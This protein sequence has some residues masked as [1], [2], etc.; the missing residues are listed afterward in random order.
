MSSSRPRRPLTLR[1]KLLAQLIGLLALISV[2]IG[3]ITEVALSSYLTQQLDSQLSG[4]YGRAAEELGGQPSWPP[5]GRGPFNQPDPEDLLVRGQGPGTLGVLITDDDI[6]ARVISSRG[7]AQTVQLPTTVRSLPLT[8]QPSTL[9]LGGDLG[10]YRLAAGRT[11]GGDVM[12]IGLPLEDMHETLMR[13]AWIMGA[14]AVTGLLATAVIGAFTVRRTLRPLNRVAD[15]ASRVA[16]M[17]LD[18]GEVALS[19]RVPDADPRT[20]VGKVGDAVNR[21]IGHVANALAVRQ[22]SETRVRQF[23][24]D[25]SHELRTPL[26]AIRGYAELTR[27]SRDEVP[28][29]IAYA[30]KRVE[31]ESARMTTLVEELLLLARLDSGRAPVHGPVD[32]S[33]VVTDAVADA[34]VAGHDHRWLLNAPGVPVIVQGDDGQLHQ[35]LTNLLGNARTHTPPGTTVSTSLSTTDDQV[36]VTVADDGP[37]IPLELQPEVFERFARGDGSR[38]RAAGSTGLGLAIVAAVVG[39]HGGTIDLTSQPG[40]TVFTIGFS[41]DTGSRHASC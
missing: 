23:V 22:A 6:E 1:A 4:S 13:L 2:L 3:V 31:S 40:Q 14:V 10:E 28:Q 8:R 15:T 41:R 35:V 16:E 24:A 7:T 39:A 21:M 30:M 32:L 25:A 11:G 19:E 36:V 37:G 17:K 29:D 5:R 26:A 12:V 18:Q 33:R 34:Q 20:E 9:D 27:R 38:S